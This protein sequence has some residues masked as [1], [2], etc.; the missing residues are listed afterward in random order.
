MSCQ[1]ISTSFD[2]DLLSKSDSFPNAPP[3]RQPTELRDT[4]ICGSGGEHRA[5]PPRITM[6]SV[7]GKL[8]FDIKPIDF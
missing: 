3:P 4:G 2:T 5:K 8:D 1:E 7:R 6:K